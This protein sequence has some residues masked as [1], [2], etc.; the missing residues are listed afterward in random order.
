MDLPFII[1]GGHIFRGSDLAA[2]EK[3]RWV[4]YITF[5]FEIILTISKSWVISIY[6]ASLIM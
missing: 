3:E 1:A 5:I 4:A 6:V 2:T